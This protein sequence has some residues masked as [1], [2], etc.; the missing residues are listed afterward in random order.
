MD[1]KLFSEVQKRGHEQVVVFHYPR[2]GLKAVIAIHN[3]VLGPALGGCRMRVYDDDGSAIE[4]ALRLSEGMTYKSSLAGLDLGGGKSCI[5]ADP[6]MK[7]GRREMFLQFARCL[8]HCG[9]RYITAEDMGTSVEDVMVMREITKFAAGFALDKGGSGDPSPWTAR[10][11]FN[12]MQAACEKRYGSKELKGKHVTV[13]GAGH[14][15][16][17][18]IKMLKDAGCKVTVCDTVESRLQEAKTKH[19]VEVVSTDAIY[20]VKAD[21]Y[22]PCAVGQTVNKATLPRLKCDIIAGAANNQLSDSSMYEMI[23]QRNIVY[24]PDFAINA[25]G[26]ISVGGEY[27]DG[28][29]KEAWVANKVRSIYD[30]IHR[31]LTESEKRKRFTE[32]VALELAKERIRDVEEKGSAWHS[33]SECTAAPK[34]TACC[35]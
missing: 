25:G 27:L 16:M 12:G 13:Q 17:Y 28:G 31:V 26:V 35:G 1:M 14:V 18:L 32:V 23:T 9:G 30:T 33:R 8:N 19:G 34:K 11:T 15:G 7:E 21:I 4:D 2:V 3:T 20:D 29:W 24:C 6:A 10:G 5:I 22:A